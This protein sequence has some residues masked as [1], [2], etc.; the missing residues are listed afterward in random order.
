[1]DMN[2]LHDEE[3]QGETLEEFL[4]ELQFQKNLRSRTPR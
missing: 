1:M 3:P 2:F 4:P